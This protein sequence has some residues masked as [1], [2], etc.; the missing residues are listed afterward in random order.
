MDKNGISIPVRAVRLAEA[1]N[2]PVLTLYTRPGCHLCEQARAIL[3]RLCSSLALTLH[4][5]DIDA[6]PAFTAR[7][8]TMVPV[9]ALAGED[10]LFW[11]FTYSS[12]RQVLA[13]RAARP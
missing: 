1:A 9:A 10:V 4:E 8:G 3:A 11:P 5:Q 13:A 2:V 7:Y 6:D 12:A